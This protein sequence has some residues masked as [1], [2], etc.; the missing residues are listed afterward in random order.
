MRFKK[1]SRDVL[2]ML[3]DNIVHATHNFYFIFLDTRASLLH[4]YNTP[5]P[6]PCSLRNIGSK[7]GRIIEGS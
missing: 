1:C 5:A 3:K 4:T 6:Y 7:P 2:P